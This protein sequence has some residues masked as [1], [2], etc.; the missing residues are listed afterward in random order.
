M[1]FTFNNLLLIGSGLLVL[2]VF[3]SKTTKYGIPVVVLFMVVGML[4]GIDGPGG[5]NFYNIQISKF[6]GTFALILIL[7]SG[8][9]DTRYTDIKPIVKRG[10][11]LSTLGVAITAVLTGV[12]I[13]YTT[14]LTIKEG[15]LLG[16]I[17]SSTDAAAVFTILRSKSMGLKNNIRPLLEFES[18]SNDP[19]AYLLT[20]TMIMLIKNPDS[21]VFGY[22]WFFIKQFAIGGA[23]GV[24]MGYAITRI[25]NRISLNFD[26]LYAV[27]LL[28]LAILSFS[29]ADF[30]GGNGF[31]SVY[32]AAIVLGNSDFIHKRSLTK[33]FDAQAWM[34]QIIMFLTL[35][36]L[37]N[38]SELVPLIGVGLL[39]SVFIILVARPIAV[40]TC[41][42]GSNFT[43]RSKIFISWVGLRGAVP[44][45]LSIYALEA[46]VEKGR[47]IFN[48]VFFISLTSVLVKGTTIPAIAKFLKLNV[49]MGIRKK[50]TLDIELANKIKS[51]VVELDVAAEY[52]C[53]GKNL[54]NLEL[55]HGITIT[56]LNRN[57]HFLVPDG[58][59]T[60]QVGDKLTILAD[61][62]TTLK[63]FH[64]KIGV[65]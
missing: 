35:G 22:V 12:F 1:E 23:V 36:L 55:P 53:V 30:L 26:G 54:V 45:I 17:I 49:P 20:I 24:A 18:G 41:L 64:K 28:G 44:I 48:L 25:M 42:W 61:S 50:S 2:S 4:A 34:V 11:V 14:E 7:F 57:G 9:L 37:V 59:T 29:L 63:A 39:F 5:I 8:G 19:M 52:H 6:I 43:T 62:V 38:P 32:L 56:M 33:H 58:F 31:L 3:L 65:A 47:L 51:I 46:G 10:I 16:A 21:S 60:I 13:T 40:L 27:L 15:L